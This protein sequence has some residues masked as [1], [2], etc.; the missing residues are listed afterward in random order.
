MS[1]RSPPS[2]EERATIAAND[3][4]R[5]LY[6]NTASE[7]TKLLNAIIRRLQDRGRFGGTRIADLSKSF[8]G[9]QIVIKFTAYGYMCHMTYHVGGRDDKGPAGAFHIKF[10]KP[11]ENYAIRFLPIINEDAT[12]H[13]FLTFAHI[14]YRPNTNYVFSG[15]HK[16]LPGN[17]PRVAN[18]VLEIINEVPLPLL[19]EDE[20]RGRQVRREETANR[21]ARIA[22]TVAMNNS[23][24]K[25]RFRKDENIGN[26]LVEAKER[27]K[28][29]ISSAYCSAGVP[30]TGFITNF[31]MHY[32]ALARFWA[33][34]HTS[35]ELS[36]Y[37]NRLV[38]PTP[39]DIAARRCC[40][41]P[42]APVCVVGRHVNANDNVPTPPGSPHRRGEGAPASD[43]APGSA[44]SAMLPSSVVHTPLGRGTK[45]RPTV[46]FRNNDSHSE[47]PNNNRI[48]GVVQTPPGNFVNNLASAPAPNGD[49]QEDYTTG[50]GLPHFNDWEIEANAYQAEK[51]AEAEKKTILGEGVPRRRKTRKSRKERKNRT[52][53]A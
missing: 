45:K 18:K 27:V 34:D 31:N 36:K 14:N 43:P 4:V 51:A 32:P 26:N 3:A 47:N 29:V 53:R 52:R 42:G 17:L 38:N 39:A 9:G 21:A 8:E 28:R 37:W 6:D 19:S 41:G 16:Q 40:G 22:Q 35:E 7:P 30:A 49:D 44:L 11:G 1:G 48:A 13:R 33:N 12:G 24:I 2:N 5:Q 25:Q 23:Q 15:F 20:L 46:Y 10:E 50:K